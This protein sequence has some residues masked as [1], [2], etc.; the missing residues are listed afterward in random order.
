ML[1]K[2]E[3]ASLKKNNTKNSPRVDLLKL[4]RKRRT[5]FI[6]NI[7]ILENKIGFLW[8]HGKKGELTEDEQKWK[9]IWTEIRNE[10]LN[11]GNNE[12]RALVK[13]IDEYDITWKRY[14]LNTIFRKNEENDG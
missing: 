12:L 4:L 10:I 14:K 9:E 7:S 3:K 6:G 8:G 5:T 13:E 2:A 1:L 11:N